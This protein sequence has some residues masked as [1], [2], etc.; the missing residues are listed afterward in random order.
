MNLKKFLSSYLPLL[1]AAVLVVYLSLRSSS[2]DVFY[3]VKNYPV[4]LQWLG[5]G[6]FM[7]DL[8][9]TVGHFLSYFVLS[10]LMFWGSWRM[11]VRRW[12]LFA[13]SVMVPVLFG[14]LMEVLQEYCTYTR[15]ADWA[16]LTADALG[17]FLAWC[18][19]AFFVWL[20]NK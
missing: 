6:V 16:D 11:G 3:L 14:G 8:K 13:L 4:V 12:R 15:Q 20:R 17:S 7:A 18:V 2:P 10:V 1:L 19:C 9:D 5:G